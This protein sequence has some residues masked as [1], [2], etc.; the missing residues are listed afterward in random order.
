[1]NTAYNTAYRLIRVGRLRANARIDVYNLTNNDAI[2]GYNS[3]YSPS[4]TTFW[5]PSSVLHP[6]FAR[7]SV[8]L[9]W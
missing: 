8:Q 4:N 5:T 3:T 9:D 1:M 2:T 6:R 7:F